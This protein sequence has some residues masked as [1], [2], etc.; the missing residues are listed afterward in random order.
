MKS[1]ELEFQTIH[2]AFRPKILRYLS[3]LVG[4][5]EAEDLTQ[6]VF[7]RVSQRLGEFRGEASLS[8][9]LYRIATNAAID[10]MR[11]PAFR[12]S[13]EQT[14]ADDPSEAEMSGR[15]IWGGEPNPTVEKQVVRDEMNECIRGLIEK[16]PEPYRLA[17]VL[18][19]LEGLKNREVADILGVSLGTVKIRLHRARKALKDELALHC[20]AYWVE[21][22]EFIPDL[23]EL[24][25]NFEK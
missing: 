1:D 2:E 3:R 18:A 13:V 12:R 21:E 14:G 8:T 22:N 4:E 11:S 6:E 20:E 17:L 10:R 25:G 19:D 5:Q 23:K 16:L 15:D 9:W 24:L 7:V